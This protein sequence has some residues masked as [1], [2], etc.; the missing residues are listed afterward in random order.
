MPIPVVALDEAKTILARPRNAPIYD[1]QAD[2]SGSA[3]PTTLSFFANLATF[4]VTPTGGS[5]VKQFGLDT[6]LEGTPG[7]TIPKGS[8]FLW[9]DLT[10]PVSFRNTSLSSGLNTGLTEEAQRIRRAR[11]LTFLFASTPYFSEPLECI[12]MGVGVDSMTTT[13]AGAAATGVN[14][15]PIKNGRLHR[16]NRRRATVAGYPVVLTQNEQFTIQY[17]AYSDFAPTPTAN[18]WW[19]PTLHGLFVKGLQG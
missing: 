13:S 10:T 9:Y 5:A 1:T 2:A 12:P 14:I 17:V 15:F 16:D 11:A 3:I 18:M 4:Q 6:N 19:T 7:G 8:M